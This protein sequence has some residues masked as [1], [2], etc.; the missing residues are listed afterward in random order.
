VWNLYRVP[1]RLRERGKLTYAFVQLTGKRGIGAIAHRNEPAAAG[2]RGQERSKREDQ[3]LGQLHLSPHAEPVPIGGHAHAHRRWLHGHHPHGRSPWPIHA[4]HRLR[5]G[6]FGDECQR[7]LGVLDQP[8][9]YPL[10]RNR[11]FQ[12]ANCIQD[13]GSARALGGQI[14]HRVH[15]LS[16]HFA[17]RTVLGAPK[18]YPSRR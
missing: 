12:E 4:G 9:D 2:T 17:P 7:Q 14:P 8:L 13:A 16:V 5:G 6:Q 1:H 15:R 3:S 18:R 11:V 10:I